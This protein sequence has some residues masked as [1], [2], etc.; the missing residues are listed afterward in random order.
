VTLASLELSLQAGALNVPVLLG[1]D[2]SARIRPPN[3]ASV[4][5]DVDLPIIVQRVPQAAQGLVVPGQVIGSVRLPAAASAEPA[6][7]EAPESASE[8]M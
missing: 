5:R 6:A 8:P 7:S 2:G 4:P 3:L 1:S